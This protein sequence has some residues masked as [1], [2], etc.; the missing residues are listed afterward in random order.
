[1]W[2]ELHP[3][4]LQV[5]RDDGCLIGYE[6]QVVGDRVSVDLGYSREMDVNLTSSV[7]VVP[8]ES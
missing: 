1:M 4:A 8:L 2:L 5:V 7:L 6:S 3:D